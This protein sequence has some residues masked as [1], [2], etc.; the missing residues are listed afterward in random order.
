MLVWSWAI[1]QGIRYDVFAAFFVVCYVCVVCYVLLMFY[2]RHAKGIEYSVWPENS[3]ELGRKQDEIE[4][5]YGFCDYFR[6]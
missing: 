6:T 3:F 1:N 2:R 5:R 4:I